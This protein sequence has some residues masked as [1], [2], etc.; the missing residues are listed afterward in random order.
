MTLL[1]TAPA[2]AV[3]PLDLGE[4]MAVAEASVKQANTTSTNENAPIELQIAATKLISARRA[5]SDRDYLRAEHLA[6]QAQVD[7]QVAQIHAE[8]VRSSKA[9]LESQDAA[10]ALV[11]EINRPNI[12]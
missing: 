8:S 7:A 5:W 10:R 11:E 9:A 12:R 1:I 4:K 3:A 2:W 6:E